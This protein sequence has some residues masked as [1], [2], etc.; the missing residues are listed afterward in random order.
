MVVVA[1]HT[2]LA[3]E[4]GPFQAE[5]FW[6]VPP[7]WLAMAVPFQVPETTVPSSEKEETCKPV[8]VN[9][10]KVEVEVVVAVKYAPTISPATESLA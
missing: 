3:A 10:G 5:E 1:I 8:V 6:P 4:T 9:L 2:P 7:Y